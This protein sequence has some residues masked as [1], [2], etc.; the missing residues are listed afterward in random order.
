MRAGLP[1]RDLKRTEPKNGS[2]FTQAESELTRDRLRLRLLAAMSD[3]Y[4]FDNR[5]KEEFKEQIKKTTE[6]ERTLLELWIKKQKKKVKY[7]DLGCGQHG[8]LLKSHEVSTD[9]DFEVDGF[10]PF[11]VK[12]ARKTLAKFFH[13]KKNQVKS[14]IRQKAYILMVNGAEENAPSYA[15]LDPDFIKM[16]PEIYE[17]VSWQGFGNKPSY[18]IPLEDLEWLS[19]K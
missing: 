7:R 19:L 10:G 8:E 2:G 13:L 9:A 17:T 4:R 15:L 1:Q 3:S 11:E 5:S 12:F 18:R 16:I 6:Q 14:Y